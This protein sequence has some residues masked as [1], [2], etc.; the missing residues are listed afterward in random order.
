GIIKEE[1]FHEQI[2]ISFEI[3][4]EIFRR[5]LLT[6]LLK[7]EVITQEFVDMLL[8]WNH[9]SGFNVHGKEIIG[10][11]NTEVIENVA[12]YMSR[13]AISTDR[14]K[15]NP[16]DNTVTVYEKQNRLDCKSKAYNILEFIAQITSHIPSPYESLVYY[17]GIYSSSHRGKEKRA[18]IENQKI[19]VKEVTGKKG[20]AGGKITSTWARLIKRIFEVDPLCCKKC[21]GEMK[22]I[23]F[24]TNRTEVKKILKHIH[25]ETVKPPPLKLIFPAYNDNPGFRDYQPSI[26]DYMRDPEYVN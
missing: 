24:I 25:E 8:S 9:N 22:I 23:A 14:V 13:A 4:T 26:D 15:F 11:G 2:N 19:E 7:A 18:N 10:T 6:E 20:I 17:Y 3:I 16:D 12:R 1:I 21:G 5:K